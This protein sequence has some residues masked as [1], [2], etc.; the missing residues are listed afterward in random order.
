[1]RCRSVGINK[2]VS[3]SWFEFNK[4]ATPRYRKWEMKNY[5]D[6]MDRCNLISERYGPDASNYTIGPPVKQI[7]RQ[8]VK[9]KL[10][11][12]ELKAGGDSLLDLL[13]RTRSHR[14]SEWLDY[15]ERHPHALGQ[16]R[17]I[18]DA[19]PSMLKHEDVLHLLKKYA[20]LFPPIAMPKGFD[21]WAKTLHYSR[22]IDKDADPADNGIRVRKWIAEK[23][24]L[25][26]WEPVRWVMGVLSSSWWRERAGQGSAYL[27]NGDLD[28]I[29]RTAFRERMG[30][31]AG[32]SSVKGFTVM[33][34]PI[35]RKE[36]YLRS[37]QERQN[38]NLT[39]MESRETMEKW[40][41]EKTWLVPWHAGVSSILTISVALCTERCRLE[42]DT[43]LKRS[44]WA[45][46]RRY[47]YFE[48]RRSI[49]NYDYGVIGLDLR[50]LKS[51]G[52]RF[53]TKEQWEGVFGSDGNGFSLRAS[54]DGD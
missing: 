9:R 24:M 36:H 4:G 14:Y 18:N 50:R 17:S 30:L 19:Y 7:P 11:G 5:L 12:I 38:S 33:V 35:L 16:V 45:S 42:I 3:H 26:G 54:T 28:G 13:G 15:E 46:S 20:P 8:S 48:D 39:Q 23:G 44:V 31:S 52:R 25:T 41:S 21:P 53:W 2:F 6:Q 1:M 32:D 22:D 40:I 49:A 29:V 43:P 51:F 47:D 34:H 27:Y 37:W 10:Y